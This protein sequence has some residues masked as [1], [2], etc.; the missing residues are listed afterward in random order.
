VA[1][2]ASFDPAA[3]LTIYRAFIEGALDVPKYL[4]RRV[5]ELD[6]EPQHAEL[7]PRTMWTLSN[8]FTPASKELEPILQFKATAKLGS[9]LKARACKRGLLGRCPLAT[10]TST[11]NAWGAESVCTRLPFLKSSRTLCPTPPQPSQLAA[12]FRPR[13]MVATQLGALQTVLELDRRST[14]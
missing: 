3:N 13:G 8:A 6:F 10:K 9:F 1:R 12:R 5:H 7:Q 2:L 4:A 14:I 11:G